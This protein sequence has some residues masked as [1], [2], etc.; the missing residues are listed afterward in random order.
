MTFK[1]KSES[2]LSSQSMVYAPLKK[3]KVLISMG[4]KNDKRLLKL[5][6]FLKKMEYKGSALLEILHKTQE[7]YG[8]LNEDVLKY[9]SEAIELPLSHVYGV[10]TFYSYFKLKQ[11]GEH[12]ITACMGTACY[13]KG[14]EKII[15]AIEKRFC[16]KR[17]G[18]TA[19]GKLSLFITRCIG[20]CAIGPTILIDDNV[21]GNA[22]KD[23]VLERIASTLESEKIY[24]CRYSKNS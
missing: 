4:L 23:I 1:K 24:T 22:T 16:V 15:S 7:I 6:R 2:F 3:P 20:A 19:D 14:V 10:A 8:Y 12:V 18:S 17:G 5:E 21:V 11:S 13:V 9:V